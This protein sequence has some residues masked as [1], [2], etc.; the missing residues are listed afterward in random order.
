MMYRRS[1]DFGESE[2]KVNVREVSGF[3]RI[4]SLACNGLSEYLEPDVAAV[5][6]E[7][8]FFFPKGIGSWRF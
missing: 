4:E 3:E 7:I 2:L 8:A 5:M 1:R 6:I